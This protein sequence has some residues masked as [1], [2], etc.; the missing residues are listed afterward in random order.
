[1]HLIELDKLKKARVSFEE[2][3]ELVNVN[4][5]RQRLMSLQPEIL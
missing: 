2:I 1:M 3:P 4:Q 5:K